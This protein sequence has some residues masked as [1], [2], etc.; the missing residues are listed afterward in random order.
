ME[1]ITAKEAAEFA[2][3]CRNAT[4]DQL[5]NIIQKELDAGR[6]CFAAIGLMEWQRR[7]GKVVTPILRQ[8]Q[9]H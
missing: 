1:T 8:V 5:D 6:E 4:D 7:T 9:L 2:A 3:F